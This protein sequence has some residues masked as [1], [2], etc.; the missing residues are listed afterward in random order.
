MLKSSVIAYNNLPEWDCAGNKLEIAETITKLTE[1][2]NRK[3]VYVIDKW[4]YLSMWTV[5]E[6]D[7]NI[8]DISTADWIKLMEAKLWDVN[9]IQEVIREILDDNE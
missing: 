3:V 6:K 1:S 9:E 7:S 5:K 8:R 4:E 2:V